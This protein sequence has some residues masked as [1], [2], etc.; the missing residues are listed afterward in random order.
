MYL[1]PTEKQIGKTS[2]DPYDTEYF[3]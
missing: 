1:G 3:L 2:S